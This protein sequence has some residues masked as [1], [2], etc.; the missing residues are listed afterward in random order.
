MVTTHE[1]TT[2]TSALSKFYAAAMEQL[3]KDYKAGLQARE[4]STQMI[5]DARVSARQAA[6]VQG[7][8]PPAWAAV[9]PRGNGEAVE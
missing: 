3:E 6:K 8:A 7:V 5:R 9:Q 2:E 4:K 1:N